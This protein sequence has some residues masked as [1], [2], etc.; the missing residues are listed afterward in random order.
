MLQYVDDGEL[1]DNEPI[2]FVAEDQCWDRATLK[3]LKKEHDIIFKTSGNG[4]MPIMILNKDSDN[5]LFVIG[6][7]DDGTLY[8]DRTGIAIPAKVPFPNTSLKVAI[9]KRAMVN[10]IPIPSPSNAE[11]KTVFLRA[12]ISARPRMI[13]FT[14]ISA[15]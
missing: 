7:E 6:H 1:E 4:V 9:S 2:M 10:P 12:N 14:T 15:R 11:S 13:Q 5:P 8:F 3:Q